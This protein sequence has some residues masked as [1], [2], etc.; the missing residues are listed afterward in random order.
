MVNI[1]DYGFYNNGNV[2]TKDDLLKAIVHISLLVATSYQEFYNST[3]KR[4][5]LLDDF[6]DLIMEH[7]KLD[8][9]EGFLHNLL[10]ASQEVFSVSNYKDVFKLCKDRYNYFLED[11]NS[12]IISTVSEAFDILESTDKMFLLPEKWF[13]S[14][15]YKNLGEFLKT[16][17][18]ER[19]KYRNRVAFCNNGEFLN[20]QIIE[21]GKR[22][23]GVSLSTKFDFYPTP[24]KLVKLVQKLADINMNDTVLEP[25]A[26]L[27]SLLVGLNKA[28]IQ[29]VE[30]NPVLAEILKAK[31]FETYNGSFEDFISFKRYS[32]IIM[33]PPFGRRLDAIHI[34]RAF[35]NFL[36][37]DGILVAI[38]SAGI[39]SGSDKESKTFQKLY[40]QYGVEQIEVEAGAFKDSAKGTSVKTCITKF[41]KR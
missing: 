18:C 7:S 39:N 40:Q 4:I 31:G 27:G 3:N 14:N 5:L 33:N 22:L 38:H 2:T 15:L 21:I 23:N 8:I 37:V 26:G 32:R 1:A 29:C 35:N 16:F 11:Y 30:I 9:E 34:N 6:I 25:S 17:G 24:E 20:E 10:E 41:Q 36:E 28:N 13:S 19:T 12:C